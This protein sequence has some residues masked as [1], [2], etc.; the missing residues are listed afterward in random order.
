MAAAPSFQD[1]YDA[2]KAEAVLRRPEL[3]FDQGDVTDMFMA[4]AGAMA[5]RLTGYFAEQFKNTYLDGASGDALTRLCND[6]WAVIRFGAVNAVGA[7]TL[8]RPTFAAGAGTY[9]AGS[10]VATQKDTFGNDVQ[11]ALDVDAVFNGTDLT[12]T[13]NVTAVQPGELGN[14]RIGTVVKF[15]TQPFDTTLMVTN[16]APIAGGTDVESDEALRERTRALPSILRRGTLDALEYGAKTVAGV[17]EAHAV[18]DPTGI[19]YVYVADAD[20]NSNP[21]MVANV[22]AALEE[23]RAAGALVFAVGGSLYDGPGTAGAGQLIIT[24]QL[25]VRTGVDVNALVAN[26]KAALVAALG[27]LRPGEVLYRALIHQ[28][29]MNVSP[30]DIVNVQVIDPAVDLAPPADQLIRTTTANISIA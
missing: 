12:K 22:Q 9:F 24:L 25:T 7:V 17:V 4:A 20:G 11:Y 23:W 13:V 18:E 3:T 30:A 21:T 26:I 10:I 8:T 29:V 5:D 2:G 28:T 16:A 1:Y 14:A 15:I 27:K 19:C 6:H